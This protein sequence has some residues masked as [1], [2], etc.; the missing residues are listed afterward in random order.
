M[1]KHFGHNVFHPHRN[2]T[3]RV[4]VPVEQTRQLKFGKLFPK[5]HSWEMVELGGEPRSG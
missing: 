2:L 3:A 1:L 5:P 4:P